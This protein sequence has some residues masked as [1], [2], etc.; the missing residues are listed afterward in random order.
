MAP[1]TLPHLSHWGAFRVTVDGDRV[2]AAAG[3]PSDPAPS[4]LLEN[5]VDGVRQDTRIARPAIRRGWLERGPGPDA[6]RGSDE[7][8]EVEWDEAQGLVADEL[9]RVRDRYGNEAIFGGSY[10]WASAGRFHHAQSQLH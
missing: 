4:P 5:F 7:F 1:R 9:R 2:V 10:G 3:H 8:V 6:A